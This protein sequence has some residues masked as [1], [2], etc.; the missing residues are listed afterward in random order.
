MKLA[1]RIFALAIVVTGFTAAAVTPGAAPVV[2]SHQSA[3]ESFPV[4]VCGNNQGS[5]LCR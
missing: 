4:P 3:T 1:L 2:R 5:W